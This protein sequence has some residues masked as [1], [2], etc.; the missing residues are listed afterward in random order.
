MSTRK[1]PFFDYPYVFKSEEETYMNI[2]KDV[3][4][5]GAFI[6]QKDLT[7][8]EKNL[9]EFVGV[10]YAVGVAN[11]TDAITMGLRAAGIKEGD[12]CI[13]SSHTFVAT[14]AA[15]HYAGGKPVPVECAPDHQISVEDIRKNITDK[16]KF[17]VPT[18]LNGRCSKMDDI[19][20]IANEYNLKIVEDSAQALGAKF[21]GQCAGTFG[22]SGSISFYPAKVLGCF[23]DAGAVFTNDEEVYKSLMI[24]RDHG[25]CPETGEVVDWGLNLR[26]DNLQAAFLNQ[27]L[28]SYPSVITRRREIAAI[29]NDRLKDLEQLAL[30]PA[31]TE[32]GDYFDIFQNYEIR[33]ERRDELKK[34]L[35]DNNIGTLCQW[36]GKAVHEFEALKLSKDLPFTEQ[37]TSTMLLLP[38]NMSVSNDDIEYVCETITKFYKSL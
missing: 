34:F 24:Q 36:G 16:T 38:I 5:R 14:A 3:C 2:F 7:E 13:F 29:Y 9:A 17:I 8:F 22:S 31:P 10:K 4:S 18:Q 21:K 26:M 35:A 32:G 12:E 23:G 25:R 15:I 19:I 11:G 30:P 37:V 1:V 27:K 20:E 28:K 6:L 33:A